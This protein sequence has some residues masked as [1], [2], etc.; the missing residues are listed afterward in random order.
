[1]ITVRDLLYWPLLAAMSFLI[2]CS[3]GGGNS[4]TPLP[5]TVVLGRG[6]YTSGT[7]SWPYELLQLSNADGGYAYA[8]WFPASS[9]TPAPVIVRTEPY[10]GIDW[11]GTEVDQRWALRG[12]GRFPDTDGPNYQSGVSATIGYERFTPDR[13]G[14]ES[15]IYLRNGFGVLTTFGRFYAGGSVWNDVQDMVAG[16][17]FLGT[18]NNVDKTRIGMFGISWGGFET[19]YGSAYA[20]AGVQPKASVA[21]APVIDFQALVGHIDNTIPVVTNATT[22]PQYNDFFDPYLRRLFATTGGRPGSPGTDFSRVTAAALGPRLN[23]QLLV[24]HDDSDTILPV[25]TSKAFVAASPV[26]AQGFWYEQSDT[27]DY[28]ANILTHGPLGN[29]TVYAPIYTFSISYLFTA[30]GDSGGWFLIPYGDA[31]LDA[32][33]QDIRTYQVGARNVAWVVPRLLELCDPR[34]YLYD[35]TPSPPIP[36]MSGAELL[37]NKINARWGTAFTPVTVCS[38]LASSGLPP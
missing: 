21:I 11:T 33:F 18:Q 1:M 12:T 35:L 27:I 6:V 24:I 20:D 9:A 26:H 5:D 10:A 23:T 29:A 25:A 4:P 28:N 36:Y 7:E 14:I 38:Q 30:L 3:G 17:K 16:L 37:S 19:A 31:D 2:S 8:Q 15:E 13:I 32:F 34:V 22:L